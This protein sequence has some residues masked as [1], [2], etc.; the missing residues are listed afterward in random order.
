MHAG[1]SE[2]NGGLSAIHA[3]LS[4]TGKTTLSNTGHPVADDQIVIE[5]DSSD[6]EAVIS[7]MEGGQYAKTENLKREKEP[8]TYDAIKWGTTAENIYHNEQGEPD[9]S[10]SSITANGRVGYPLEYVPTAKKTG[11]ARAPTNITFLTADGFGVLPP[12]ARLTV[13]QGRG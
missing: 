10:N 6:T 11:C 7:N 3:G 9:Y 4:G 1:A 5:I 2:G 12:V 13:E 8:E